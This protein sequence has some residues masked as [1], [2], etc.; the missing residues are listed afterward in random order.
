MSSLGERIKSI[1]QKI[2]GAFSEEHHKS[3]KSSRGSQR[4]HP[5]ALDKRQRNKK[6]T[7]D[8]LLRSG[9]QNED[10]T[11][12]L[13]SI[14]STKNNDNII[15]ISQKEFNMSMNAICDKRI[16]N[17]ITFAKSMEESKEPKESNSEFPGLQVLFPF[18]GNS[19]KKKYSMES[20]QEK[21]NVCSSF[22]N[23]KE[24]LEEIFHQIQENCLL[25]N[26]NDK[27]IKMRN[28]SFKIKVPKNHTLS[29]NKSAPQK[30]R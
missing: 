22:A 23:E 18:E 5:V 28:P 29:R 12:S 17:A 27:I 13:T 19:N 1:R 24:L 4:L 10:I 6:N 16:L 11:Y 7:I 25:G 8:Q 21:I 3:E 9:N 14:L 20:V 26:P 2:K 15:S 30:T